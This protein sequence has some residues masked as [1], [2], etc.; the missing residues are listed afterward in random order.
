MKILPPPPHP[1][2]VCISK[3][4]QFSWSFVSGLWFKKHSTNLEGYIYIHISFFHLYTNAS[5]YI[6]YISFFHFIRSLGDVHFSNMEWFLIKVRSPCMLLRWNDATSHW[7]WWSLEG[8][9]K[10]IT[11][12]AFLSGCRLSN[13]TFLVT[14]QIWLL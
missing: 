4:K 3:D 9:R 2:P 14:F 12:L 7:L 10:V 8:V 1:L 11:M 13:F 5:D 6:L